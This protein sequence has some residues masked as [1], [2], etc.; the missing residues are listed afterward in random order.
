MTGIMNTSTTAPSDSALPALSA[1]YP[2]ST[3]RNC[4]INT[5]VP[6]ITMPRMNIMIAAIRKFFNRSSCKSTIGFACRHSLITNHVSAMI[7]AARKTMIRRE[8]NQSSSWPLSRTYCRQP[9]PTAI[10][11]SPM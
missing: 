7:E 8:E 9:I 11:P 2:I 10:N 5:V 1:L 4:G 6:N 3:W